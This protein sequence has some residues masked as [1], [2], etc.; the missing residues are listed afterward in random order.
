MAQPWVGGVPT[1]PGEYI[2]VLRDGVPTK[3]KGRGQLLAFPE[4]VVVAPSGTTPTLADFAVDA[5]VPPG[6]WTGFTSITQA[7]GGTA[8]RQG[9][10][11]ASAAT[12]TLAAR[13]PTPARTRPVADLATNPA[14]AGALHTIANDVARRGGRALVVGGAVR[15]LVLA[16]LRH[17]T[18]P[19][20]DVDIEV[21]G[22]DP[23]ELQALVAARHR[24]DLTGASFAVLKAH[25]PG[26]DHPMDISIPRR[27]RATG[28]GHRDFIVDADPSLSF[29]QAAARRDFTI[30]A[31]GF[32]PLTGELIDPY[33]GA[34]DL[35]AGVLRHVGPAFDEDP[36]RALRAARFAARY[37]LTLHPDTVARCRALRS[38]AQTLPAERRWGELAATLHQA[39][40][41]GTA[42]HV[43]NQIEW[44]DLF[45]QLAATR[46]VEQDPT[47]HPEGDVFVHTAAVLDYWG[48]NLRTGNLAAMCH[49]FGKATTTEIRQGRLTAHG[50][51]QA[52]VAPATS[53]LHDLGQ[54]ALAK[55]VAPLIAHH[56]APVQLVGSSNTALR[57][58]AL[59]VPRMDLLA[60]V[61]KADQGGRPPKDP[62]EALA[63]IDEFSDRAKNLGV[64]RGALPNL[65]KG[66]DLIAMGL[67]PGPIFSKLLGAAYEAQLEGTV[68]TREQARD[69]L[70]LLVAKEG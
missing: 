36:L 52:G 22:I 34:A 5:L 28:L 53:F 45:E 41:P 18:I 2:W 37:D 43:L 15:D 11:L 61:A 38:Q 23:A 14:V 20:I 19:A 67:R 26:S 66:E 49:D 64:T 58:L 4:K 32:D 16:R 27:E 56:L 13:L 30:G 1:T 9:N 54:V 51:E 46:G 42:L 6:V 69:L 62:T 24:V 48:K 70:S 63:V 10:V 7:R 40:T 59:K 68:T 60:L 65:A 57:R 35:A 47:W 29:A 12:P 33:G 8:K 44:I 50:H 31:M 21:F 17:T 55:D 3:I 25:V 39:P